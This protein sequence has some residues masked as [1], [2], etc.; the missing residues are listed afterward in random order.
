MNDDTVLTLQVLNSGVFKTDKLKKLLSGDKRKKERDIQRLIDLN[1]KAF[2]YLG[3]DAYGQYDDS[4]NYSLC[5]KTSEYSGVVPLRSAETGLICGYLKVV[6]R[7]GED[8]DGIL[9]LLKDEDFTPDFD[10][11]M[12][13]GANKAVVP[14]K[15]IECAKFIDM[16]VQADR[17]HW[18]KFLSRK[19][20][21]AKPR[22]TDWTMYSLKSYNPY[23]ALKYPNIANELTTKHSEW[24]ALQYVL[25][26]AISEL[27]SSKTPRAVKSHYA[28][29]MQRLEH[30][31]K[32]NLQV[33]VHIDIHA[34][35]PPIIKELKKI[36]N[37]ILKNTSDIRC[38][39]R[40][41]YSRF[42]ERYVQYIF[43]QL[44][45]KRGARVFSNPHYG[46]TGQKPAWGLKYLEPDIVLIKDSNQVVVDAK[47]KSHIY[48]WDS[49]SMELHNTFR[50]DF[51]QI[52]AYSSLSSAQQK[53]TII[54]YPYKEFKLFDTTV[55]S[56]LNECES[57]AFLIG[58]PISK[59]AIVDVVD[60][61]SN[62]LY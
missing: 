42:F 26:L 51:H 1:K 9:P 35:D 37:L 18:Q 38:A 13:I 41:D 53:R 55:H 49:N 14:P 6:G 34:S 19:I 24:S 43:E 44:A 21:Q 46:I 25:S 52:L 8:I 59:S 27:R 48:N 62:I 61:L 17:V 12:P 3:I 20:T 47:Y 31:V 29:I 23:N 10:D 2:V 58:I 30:D 36:A 40:I 39:W 60:S 5:L 22:N 50:E 11:T 45:Y 57:K 4:F 54:V 7:Y 56:S 32:D 33:V 16:Y 28:A 15:Y